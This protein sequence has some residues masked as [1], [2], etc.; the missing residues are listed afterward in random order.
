MS[1]SICVLV[2]NEAK[3]LNDLLETFCLDEFPDVEFIVVD[4]DSIDDTR[5]VAAQFGAKVITSKASYDLARNEYIQAAAQ[6]WILV[7]DVD[8]RISQEALKEIILLTKNADEKIMGFL[9]PRYDYCG[10]GKWASIKLLRLFR[11]DIRIRYNNH[12]I[13]GSVIPSILAA[14]GDIVH[15]NTVIHHLD[16]LLEKGRSALKRE[17][18]INRLLHEINSNKIEAD[19][20]TMHFFLGLEYTALKQFDKAEKEYHQ[21]INMLSNT[22]HFGR[23]FLAQHHLI[24]NDLEN[25]EKEVQVLLRGNNLNEDAL[26]LL[27]EISIRRGLINEAITYIETII[28]TNLT[29]AHHFINLASLLEKSDPQIAFELLEK[30]AQLNPLLLN[31]MIYRE[32]DKPNI[33]EQQISFLSTTKD[34]FQNVI[35]CLTRLD[36]TRE[37]FEYQVR[38]KKVIAERCSE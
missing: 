33:F 17:R 6:P 21:A 4:N 23:L 29:A 16:I 8:E 36:R 3:L 5:E 22:S 26:F 19:H 14:G 25:A 24:N 11:N 28:G 12:V 13:H 32:G 1:I 34:W 7:L 20:T 35:S 31:D 9:L 15:A 2:K 10:D 30:A 18:N 38:Y 27:A 37:A